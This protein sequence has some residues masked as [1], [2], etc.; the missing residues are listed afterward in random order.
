MEKDI[1]ADV[2]KKKPEENNITSLF[3]V[4]KSEDKDT[5]LLVKTGEN[6]VVFFNTGM[7]RTCSDLQ[8]YTKEQFLRQISTYSGSAIIVKFYL[9]Q[10]DFSKLPYI[11]FDKVIGKWLYDPDRDIE[12]KSFQEYFDI[13]Q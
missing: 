10:K 4:V 11:Y 2:F 7:V 12:I 1:F 13:A 6:Y 9:L 3:K 8:D 5:E